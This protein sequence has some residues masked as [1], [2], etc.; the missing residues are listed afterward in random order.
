[1]SNNLPNTFFTDL[2][3]ELGAITQYW[4]DFS[5][6]NE[7]GGFIGQRDHY[8]KMIPNASKGIILNA[9]ILW[10]FSAIANYD[11]D[12]DLNPF[13][14]R[15]FNYLYDFFRDKEN[16]GVFWELNA[17]GE[18]IVKKKQIYA[19]AFAIYALSE[20][21]LNTQNNKAKEWAIELFDLIEKHA[22]DTEKDG[23]IEAFE[24]DWS[25]IADMR[26]SDKDQN[27]AKTMNTHLHVLEAYTTLYK[28]YPEE[29]VKK[30]L[31][32]LIKLFLEKFLNS[33]NNFELFFDTDW[34]LTSDIVSFGHDIEAL[35]LLIEGAKSS[36]NKEL[37]LKTQ[38]AAVPVADKFLE[39]G[40][41][42]NKGVLN[43][44][45]RSNG[46][47]DTDRHWWPQAEAMVG[48]FYANEIKSDSRYTEAIQDIW[49]FTKDHIIDSKNGEWFFRVDENFQPYKNE[50]KLG[51][52]KCPYHN[53]RACIVLLKK[54]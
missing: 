31:D 2:K 8:N 51:M 46:E 26:L 45:E 43:E 47:I 18:P 28:I 35:W 50:D 13:M 14:E 4:K 6:D 24:A 29:R 1:M 42:K 52:W 7:N 40:Y 41:I 10:S 17:T 54:Q 48:L 44:K 9:R 27:A 15:A 39:Y 21:Y 25:P 49:N 34:N 11:A 20:Y 19:Q 53:S 12:Y 3:Q 32:N 16:G 30:A 36:G 23:Y 38:E 22:F 33:E 37:L 5:V